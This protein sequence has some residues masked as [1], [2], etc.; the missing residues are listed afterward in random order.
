MDLESCAIKKACSGVIMILEQVIHT[1]LLKSYIHIR[2]LILSSISN[3]D[4]KESP[5]SNTNKLHEVWNDFEEEMIPKFVSS[6]EMKGM[7]SQAVQLQDCQF[8]L[9]ISCYSD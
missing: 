1:A 6:D 5:I 2:D 8:G 9:C 4:N 3:D 7:T